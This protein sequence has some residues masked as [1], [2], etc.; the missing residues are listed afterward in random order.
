MFEHSR[1]V[2]AEASN[3]SSLPGHKGPNGLNEVVCSG[4]RLR[5]CQRWS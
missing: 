2:A 4:L 1:N 3:G 5:F